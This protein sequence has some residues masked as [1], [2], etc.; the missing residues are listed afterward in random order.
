MTERRKI[1][2]NKGLHQKTLRF[3]VGT[4]AAVSKTHSNLSTFWPLSVMGQL[5]ISA[6]HAT[7]E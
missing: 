1:Q 5:P 6:G 3:G 7:V 4:N 2:A